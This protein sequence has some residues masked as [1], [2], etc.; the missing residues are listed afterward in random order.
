[1][2][3]TV[4]IKVIGTGEERAIHKFTTLE[5]AAKYAGKNVVT[6]RYSATMWKW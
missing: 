4:K 5:Q 6:G 3:Y 1:M 2:G